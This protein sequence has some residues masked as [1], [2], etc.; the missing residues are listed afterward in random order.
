MTSKK[1]KS[2]LAIILLAFFLL[3]FLSFIYLKYGETRKVVNYIPI[4]DIFTAYQIEDLT[5][6]FLDRPFIVHFDGNEQT[7]QQLPFIFEEVAKDTLF[8]LLTVSKTGQHPKPNQS[9]WGY[10]NVDEKNYDSLARYVFHLVNGEID[11]V[12]QDTLITDHVIMINHRHFILRHSKLTNEE[13]KD[14]LVF[15]LKKMILKQESSK[16]FQ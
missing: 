9:N 8:N 12:D 14:D 11:D 3:P 10:L 5:D 4:E 16:I 13:E 1:N 2:W 7:V 6:Q 15:D